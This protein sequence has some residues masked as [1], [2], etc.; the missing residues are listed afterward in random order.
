LLLPLK[1]NLAENIGGLAFRIVNGIVEWEKD[2][3]M[4]TA[5]EA[6]RR[7]AASG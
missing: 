7:G 5:D 6:V 3:V 4:L 2:P 1:N